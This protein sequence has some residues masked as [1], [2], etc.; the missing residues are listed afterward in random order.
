MSA[1]TLAMGRESHVVPEHVVQRVIVDLHDRMKIRTADSITP[2]TVRDSLRHMRL[3][4]YYENTVQI[5]C[6][7]AGRRR[8][9]LPPPTVER[10]RTLFLQLLPAFS[11]AKSSTRT[12]FLSYSLILYRLFQLTGLH[13]MCENVQLLKGRDKLM[14]N[15]QVFKRMCSI[16]GWPVQDWPVLPDA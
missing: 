13:F 9:V 14:A 7:I 4:K 12:N 5:A 3:R 11:K 8:P 16:L 10:L 2:R 1:L 15:D 6:R